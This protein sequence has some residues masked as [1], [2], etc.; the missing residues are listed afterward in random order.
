MQGGNQQPALRNRS[1]IAGLLDSLQDG[2][3]RIL[4]P[5]REQGRI[6]FQQGSFESLLPLIARTRWRSPAAVLVHDIT[7][8]V[9]TDPTPATDTRREE[10]LSASAQLSIL[11]WR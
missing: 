9:N 2:V 3:F 11:D 7:R 10:G 4:Q 6:P 8:T 5:P 1:S